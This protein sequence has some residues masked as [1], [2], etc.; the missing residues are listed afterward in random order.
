MASRCEEKH[1]LTGD[2]NDLSS[3]TNSGCILYISRKIFQL[4]HSWG[5]H[6]TRVRIKFRNYG[7]FKTTA[8]DTVVLGITI[9]IRLFKALP[10]TGLVPERLIS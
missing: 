6:Y 10:Y 3:D 5:A 7:I 1:D 2:Y 9:T 8:L 4:P